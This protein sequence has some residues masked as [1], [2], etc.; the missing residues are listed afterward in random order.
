MQGGKARPPARRWWVP[1]CPASSPVGLA[2]GSRRWR[3]RAASQSHPSSACPCRELAVVLKNDCCREQGCAE[4]CGRP[5]ARVRRGGCPGA[6]HRTAPHCRPAGSASL[7]TFVPR[8]KVTGNNSL[9]S[10]P[11]SAFPP[12]GPKLW[13]GR[14]DGKSRNLSPHPPAPRRINALL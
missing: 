8:Q 3:L 9:I 13:G 6:G 1:C 14:G 11:P 5:P 12:S 2:L 10:R 4:G 7:L